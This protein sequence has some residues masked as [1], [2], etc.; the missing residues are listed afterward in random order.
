MPRCGKAGEVKELRP[1]HVQVRRVQI[2]LLYHISDDSTFCANRPQ[3]TDLP[4][5]S[6]PITLQCN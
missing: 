5:L 3:S 4:F 6:G 2:D 1:K